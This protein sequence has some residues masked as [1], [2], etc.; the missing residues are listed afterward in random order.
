MA[1]SVKFADV[2]D[3][4]N[5]VTLEGAE[6]PSP[7]PIPVRRGRV[8]EHDMRRGAAGAGLRVINDQGTH[9]SYEEWVFSSSYVAPANLTA[10]Q[11]KYNADPR[12]PVALSVDGGTTWYKCRWA[13]DGLIPRNWTA[14]YTRQAVDFHLHSLGTFTP[15]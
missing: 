1:R 6:A 15:S 12:Q 5:L 7:H 9:A 11:S 4:A 10:L 8:H 14:D 2:P 13:A 3:L